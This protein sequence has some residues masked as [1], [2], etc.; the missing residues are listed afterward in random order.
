[1]VTQLNIVVVEDNTDLRTLL[2]KA[3]RK[4]GHHVIP[5]SCAEELEDQAGSDHADAFLIDIN[6]PGE[7]GLTLAKRIRKAHPLV[8][9]IML[10]ARSA[11]DD[12]LNGYDCGADIYLTKPV[13]L[14]ELSAAL[15]SFARR[16]MATLT[17]I[18]PQGL[19]LNKLELQGKQTTVKLTTQEAIVLTALARAPAGRLETWQIADLLGAQVDEPFKASLAVRM[20]R[21]RK[22][23]MDTGAEGVVIESLRNIGY[24]LTTHI[25]IL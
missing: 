6:L 23:L 22:K 21:L 25:Q 10:S 9:I 14:P 5:L 2:E 17:H 7:D 12:K 11:L 16:R 13:S 15:R 20:V 1:M 3:L 8:G 24:K 4:D 19:T 18:T